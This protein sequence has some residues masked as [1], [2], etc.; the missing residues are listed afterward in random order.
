MAGYVIL[1]C[2]LYVAYSAV[3]SWA[4]SVI[5]KKIKK[6]SLFKFNFLIFDK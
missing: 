3:T 6:K 2:L 4:V 5:K 1:H